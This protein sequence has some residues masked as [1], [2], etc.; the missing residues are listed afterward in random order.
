MSRSRHPP[1]PWELDYPH[2]EDLWEARY[3]LLKAYRG[4]A[5]LP[6][7]ETAAQVLARAQISAAWHLEG[8]A[9]AV[10]QGEQFTGVQTHKRRVLVDQSS[11]A[12]DIRQIWDAGPRSPE[13]QAFVDRAVG[14]WRQVCAQGVAVLEWDRPGYDDVTRSFDELL[15]YASDAAVTPVV[16][17]WDA[18]YHGE[19]PPPP[20]PTRTWTPTPPAPVWRWVEQR[21]VALYLGFV[22]GVAVVIVALVTPDRVW[23][24]LLH[25]LPPP[26]PCAEQLA[27]L[28]HALDEDG[29]DGMADDPAAR[30]L[31]LARLDAGDVA[32]AEAILRASPADEVRLLGV[33]VF[34]Y[35]YQ[36][37]PARSR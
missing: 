12:W 24:D 1:R 7:G 10:F 37:A 34:V 17:A 6:A 8:L 21:F 13:V 31:A 4:E 3:P 19:P 14:C 18:D 29:L 11:T 15:A 9:R 33:R 16:L 36:C 28:R 5:A 2:R 30:V 25:P 27:E 23:R 32:A 22:V 26:Q 20:D 35:G